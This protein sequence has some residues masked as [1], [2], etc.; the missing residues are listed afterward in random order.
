MRLPHLPRRPPPDATHMMG[1]FSTTTISWRRR[2]RTPSAARAEV[3]AP[4]AAAA[5]EGAPGAGGA[6][7]VP[8]QGLDLLQLVGAQVS[9]HLHLYL[10]VVVAAV[11]LA[12]LW[13]APALQP[14][15]G[16]R[17]NARRNLDLA[18]TVDRLHLQRRAEDGVEATY[19]ALGVDVER[20]ALE[21]RGVPDLDGDVQVA[22]RAALLPLVAL[23]AHAQ[24]VASVASGRELHRD[25]L[26]LGPR[27][28]ASAVGAQGGGVDS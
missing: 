7:A 19:G 12:K 18:D 20:F 2:R 24:L 21:I 15:L 9:G 10:N 17:L 13:H 23:A 14:H 4:R 26:G 22:G 5:S 8:A 16:A 1:L 3:G 6:S 25:L 11:G 28:R 27:P